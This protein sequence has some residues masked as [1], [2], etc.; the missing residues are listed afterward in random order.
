[1]L[2]LFESVNEAPC[3]NKEDRLIAKAARDC[4]FAKELTMCASY[5]PI[6]ASLPLSDAGEETGLTHHTLFPLER[7]KWASVGKVPKRPPPPRV[8]RA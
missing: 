2:F 7:G 3:L 1:M 6:P 8:D 5:K 4:R